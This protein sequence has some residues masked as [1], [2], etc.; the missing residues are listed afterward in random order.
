MVE[1]WTKQE[2]NLMQAASKA[3]FAVCLLLVSYLANMQTDK[4]NC[5]V[6]MYLYFI[7]WPV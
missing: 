6:K 5:K 2:T 4:A 1:E 7:L 3:L